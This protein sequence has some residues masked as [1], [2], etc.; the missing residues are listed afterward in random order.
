MHCE[1]RQMDK[2]CCLQYDLISVHWV[3]HLQRKS[4]DELI[5]LCSKICTVIVPLSGVQFV[6][7]LDRLHSLPVETVEHSYPVDYESFLHLSA[8]LPV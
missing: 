2:N 6:V 5:E 7:R 4:N 8:T 3:I 1:K